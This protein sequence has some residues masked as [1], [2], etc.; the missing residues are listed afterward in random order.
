[1][2][3]H[4]WRSPSLVF[5]TRWTN[6]PRQFFED[7]FSYLSEIETLQSLARVVQ[8]WWNANEPTAL[9]YYFLFILFIIDRAYILCVVFVRCGSARADEVLGRAS[10]TSRTLMMWKIRRWGMLF[11]WQSLP[12][13]DGWSLSKRHHVTCSASKSST[14]GRHTRYCV[15]YQLEK[16]QHFRR[17]CLLAKA[18]P[19]IH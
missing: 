16:L 5:D 19:C 15:K 8:S 9:S 13:E 14:R 11:P 2:G 4:N 17:Q 10:E 18:F 1:M 3:T 6:L 12:L 7:T